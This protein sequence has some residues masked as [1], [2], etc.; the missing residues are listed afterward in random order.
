MRTNRYFYVVVSLLFTLFS[1]TISAQ[2]VCQTLLKD[3]VFDTSLSGKDS[4]AADYFRSRY[5]NSGSS[6]NSTSFNMILPID[7]IPVE[8]GAKQGGN[9]T[10]NICDE[11]ISSHEDW[12]KF[13]SW[14]KTASPVLA[15]AFVE[16]VKAEG[17]QL[18]TER[19]QV[20]NAFSINVRVS[21][22]TKNFPPV[23][24][25]FGF[26]PSNVVGVCAPLTKAK[27]QAG[28][29]VENFDTFKI[30]CSM[31]SHTQGIDVGLIAE[32]SSIPYQNMSVRPYN[33]RPIFAMSN[34]ISSSDGVKT[35]S[36]GDATF[37]W[38]SD[39]LLNRYDG[40]TVVPPTDGITRWASWSIDGVIPGLYR[41]YAT[42]A[43]AES[44]PLRLLVDGKVQITDVAAKETGGWESA[45]RQQVSAGEV[46]LNNQH[47]EL[48]LETTGA[49][50]HFKEM[51]LVFVAD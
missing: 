29:Y 41:V 43:A 40:S 2:Q 49:W 19:S 33:P 42:Y 18:W 1:A 26:T 34:N 12:Q 36:P 23:K 17:I 3:G 13:L 46:R 22:Q 5:C 47:T 25:K 44:R 16:C 20:T 32:G 11:K 8:F 35:S 48:R 10:H 27:L 4:Y 15:N 24:L 37:L 50:P 51:R 9:S 31:T 28:V 14:S 45:K 30:N 7:V 6:G 39:T 21:Y 38:G